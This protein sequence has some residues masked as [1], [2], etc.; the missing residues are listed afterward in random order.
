VYL[1][2]SFIKGIQEALKNGDGEAMQYWIDRDQRLISILKEDLSSILPEISLKGLQLLWDSQKCIQDL[3][4]EKK[5][6]VPY[7]K[8]FVEY[9]KSDGL[10]WYMK[11]LQYSVQEIQELYTFCTLHGEVELCK[12]IHHCDF[13]PIESLKDPVERRFQ[14]LERWIQ[15]MM[16]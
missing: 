13:Y 11:A 2:K 14:R 12:A 3:L 4:K 9:F 5:D 8:L 1:P 7:A 10:I 16:D 15:N 6:I